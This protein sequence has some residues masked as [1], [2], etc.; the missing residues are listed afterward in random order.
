MNYID[1]DWVSIRT[2]Y[3]LFEKQIMSEK[4]HM[5]GIDPYAWDDGQ[6]MIWMTPI[7]SA[8]WSDIR[9]VGIVMYPQYPACGFFLDFANPRAKVAIECDGREFHDPRKDAMRDKTLQDHGWTVYRVPGWRCLQDG[10]VE[11]GQYK[12]SYCEELCKRIGMEHGIGG[13][14]V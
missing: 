11:E 1:N 4:P 14:F 9:N 7:E 13:R 8:M 2:H 3:E 5:Y 6:G 10:E 12:P